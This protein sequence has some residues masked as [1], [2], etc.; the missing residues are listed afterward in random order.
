[1]LRFLGG[2]LSFFGNIIGWFKLRWAYKRG[3][4]AEQLKQAKAAKKRKDKQHE[5]LR[6][7]DR[8]VDD[9]LRDG[10]F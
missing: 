6:P 3:R 10:D 9:S 4:Q 7:S 1:M 2:L 8:D 5:V